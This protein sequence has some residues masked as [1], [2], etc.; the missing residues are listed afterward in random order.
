[1]S[2][3]QQTTGNSAHVFINRLLQ[4]LWAD[5]VLHGSNIFK[6][7]SQMEWGQDHSRTFKCFSFNQWSASAVFGSLLSQSQISG[8]CKVPLK[9]VSVFS[10]SS[11]N[12]VQF[13]SPCWWKTAPQHD[14]VISTTH[15]GGGVLSVMRG[16]FRWRSPGEV[17]VWSY[18]NTAPSPT[19][20]QKQFQKVVFVFH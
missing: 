14:T 8:R 6:L 18:M 19:R 15:S 9:N 13:S 10:P 12:S 2:L 20:L 4:I 7:Y 16:C 17:D 3:I 1:M 5:W 11:F